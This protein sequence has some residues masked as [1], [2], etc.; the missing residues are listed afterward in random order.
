MILV[1]TSPKI[2]P[3]SPAELAAVYHEPAW[4]VRRA[5]SVLRLPALQALISGIIANLERPPTAELLGHPPETIGLRAP[6]PIA[7]AHRACSDELR[8]ACG[9]TDATAQRALHCSR[10][11]GYMAEQPLAWATAFSEALERYRRAASAAMSV[12]LDAVHEQ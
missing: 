2:A 1:A 9:M 7:E 4:L 11:R 8:D 6:D 3:R 10:I 12:S 5:W